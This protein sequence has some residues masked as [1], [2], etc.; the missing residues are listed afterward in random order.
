LED[1]PLHA[2]E[3]YR[4]MVRTSEGGAAA[5]RP[6][7]YR[8]PTTDSPPGKFGLLRRLAEAAR[9]RRDD[10]TPAPANVAP[11]RLERVDLPAFF[12]RGKPS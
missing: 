5:A 10:A 8:Q 6:A 4:A 12:G 3:A 2:Q 7:V 9:G 1:F 11:D